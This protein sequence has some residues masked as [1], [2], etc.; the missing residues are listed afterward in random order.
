ME[1]INKA[2]V[3]VAFL[4]ILIT[5]SGFSAIVTLAILG[6]AIW[7]VASKADTACQ[8]GAF[9]AL[10][11]TLLHGV[12]RLVVNG[13]HDIIYQIIVWAK[14]NPYGA[15][16]TVF[17]IIGFL[18]TLGIIGLAGLA[19]SRLAAGKP[20]ETPVVN[21]YAKKTFGLFVAKP[22]QQQYYQQQP[23]NAANTWVCQNCGRQN[24]GQFCQGCGKPKQ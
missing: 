21:T 12:I 19:L 5:A 22:V 4:L 3:S 10:Y 9:E 6:I 17:N 1:K 11:L 18:I 20:S 16:S 23:M 8:V 2:L 7:A 24:D 15:L 13:M 14:G